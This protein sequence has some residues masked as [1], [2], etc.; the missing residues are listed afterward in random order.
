MIAFHVTFF[1][2]LLDT[3]FTFITL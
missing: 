1:Y 2:L 3:I